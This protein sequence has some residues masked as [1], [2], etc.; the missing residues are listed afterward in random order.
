MF[1]FKRIVLAFL[2]NR[3]F[4][5]V[6]LAIP[7]QLSDFDEAGTGGSDG[8]ELLIYQRRAGRKK[9]PAKEPAYRMF[10]TVFYLRASSR[11]RLSSR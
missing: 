8:A 10:K 4:T 9:R 1:F 5:A 7:A 2:K 6:S 11:C 3:P